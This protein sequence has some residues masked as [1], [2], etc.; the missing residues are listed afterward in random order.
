MVYVPYLSRMVVLIVPY[1]LLILTNWSNVQMEM[2]IIYLLNKVT[3]DGYHL[4]TF[5][6]ILDHPVQKG[7]KILYGRQVT[8][9]HKGRDLRT[10]QCYQGR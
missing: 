8:I 6:E 4:W 3:E 2:K 1:P 9:R 7:W 5:K 10:R